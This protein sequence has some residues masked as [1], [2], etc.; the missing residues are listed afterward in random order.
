MA[1]EPDYALFVWIRPTL[2]SRFVRSLGWKVE[3]R[4]ELRKA[5]ADGWLKSLLFSRIGF[6]VST[7]WESIALQLRFCW[8]NLAQRRLADGAKM[9]CAVGFSGMP[10]C[11]LTVDTLE[12]LS[13]SSSSSVMFS[14]AMHHKM[15]HSFL[16]CFISTSL[17]KSAFNLLGRCRNKLCRKPTQIEA[18]KWDSCAPCQL[19]FCV[20]LRFWPSFRWA[21]S[22][23]T[24]L[25]QA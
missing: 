11:T 14:C 8:R 12:M 2:R 21:Q 9:D 22:H 18:E 6:S 10:L 7:G 15:L 25:T 4:S 23:V 13:M 20:R 16:R 24:H 17:A 3:E 1:L 5:T 19:Q